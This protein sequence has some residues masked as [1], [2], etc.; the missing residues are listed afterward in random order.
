[1]VA[2]NTALEDNP[3]LVNSD[4]YGEGWMIEIRLADTAALDSLMTAEDYRTL[5]EQA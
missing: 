4:P 1:M 3:E 5:T 2:C